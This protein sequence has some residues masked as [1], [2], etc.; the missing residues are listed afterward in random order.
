VTLQSNIV[1]SSIIIFALL[2]LFLVTIGKNLK[3][4]STPANSIIDSF[5]L[6]LPV[7]GFALAVIL[8][9]WVW[10]TFF[11]YS[12]EAYERG[13]K[14][15]VI[16][17]IVNFIDENQVLKYS[18]Q[19]ESSRTLSD[20]LGSQIFQAQPNKIIQS[21]TIAGRIGVTDISFSE[22][23]AEAEINGNT[24]SSGLYR[25]AVGSEETS[26]I[27]TVVLYSYS[28]FFRAFRGCFYILNRLCRGQ[29]INLEHFKSDIIHDR[30]IR[31][32]IFKGLFFVGDFNK[33]FQGQT[34]VVPDYAER[35][36]GNLAQD[37]QALNQQRGQLV[38]LEDPEFEKLFA[39]YST[40]QIEARY[41]LSTSLMQRLVDFTKKARR[42]LFV[43]FVD[44]KIY[45]AIQYD[46]DLF[47]PK[48]FKNMVDF[49]PVREYFET[50]QL[51]I[52]IVEE[53]NLNR[54]IWT[55]R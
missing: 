51:M 31:S 52:G 15:K 5:A 27:D 49:T 9:M 3:E 26:P 55:K 25:Y 39:V 36:L 17:K 11:C 54:R 8:G 35:Y 48:L 28:L 12:V 16:H 41:L 18:Q 47:E 34:I 23:C 53:L 6:L 33:H 50:L 2:L 42:S 38:R 4:L 30:V 10:V 21:D 40:D 14:A 29:R 46:E 24:Q 1:V 22:I 20:F 7:F 44:D 13:F 43:S 37:L 45:M 19:H 32:Q